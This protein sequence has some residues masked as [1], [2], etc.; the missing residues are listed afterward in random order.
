MD[1][2]LETIG[3]PNLLEDPE[4]LAQLTDEQLDLLATVRD[5]ASD[6]VEA[7]PDDEQNIDAVYLAHMTLT[8]ALFLRA[9][10]IDEQPQALPPG[11][12]LARS[13]SGEPL[14][15]IS[16]EALADMVVP[17]STL[18]ILT[19]CGLPATA[20]PGLTFD[21]TPIRLVSV[22]DVPEEEQASAEEFFGSFWRIAV[23]EEGDA[24]CIDERGDG[25]VVLL[26]QNWGYYAQQFVNTSVGHFL[27]CLEAWRALEAD[28]NSE[29]EEA[30][31]AFDRA[32]ERIDVAALTEGAFWN[33]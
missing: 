22:M 29:Y 30:I 17:T 3:L 28:E 27:L 26:D 16:R 10:M 7:N 14:R 32:V 9:L 23:T 2:R 12:V 8:S 5:E 15:K 18:D 4:A 19:A 31:S 6:A 25:V 11:A 24:I 21:E 1:P 13:W 20:S 33:L